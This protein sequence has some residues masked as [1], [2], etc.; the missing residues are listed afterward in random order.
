MSV[1]RAL[2]A[3]FWIVV[4]L[5]HGLI[6]AAAWALLPGG[7]PLLHARFMANRLLPAL[8]FASVLVVIVQA[9]RRSRSVPALLLVYPSAWLGVALAASIAFP[10]S[11]RSVALVAVT[12]ALLLASALVQSWSRHGRPARSWLAL[13]LGLALGSGFVLAQRAPEPS[14]RPFASARARDSGRAR[15]ALGF[16]AS[17]EVELAPWLR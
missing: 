5:A 4:L 15:P 11:G 7:F 14:T 1:T 12:M 17:D 3:V 10:D 16:D 6:A 13:L 2:V 9:L 8:L